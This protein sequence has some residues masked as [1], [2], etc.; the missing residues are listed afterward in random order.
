MYCVESQH[1]CVCTR[2]YVEVKEL[3]RGCVMQEEWFEITG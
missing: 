2:S 1:L 3:T